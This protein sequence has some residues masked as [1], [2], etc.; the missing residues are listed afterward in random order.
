MPAVDWKGPL[1]RVPCSRHFK[2]AP[3][4]LPLEPGRQAS[5]QPLGRP[6]FHPSPVSGPSSHLDAVKTGLCSALSQLAH[7]SWTESA[8]MPTTGS[9]PPVPAFAR[10]ATTTRRRRNRPI[11]KG[12]GTGTAFPP[13]AKCE[14]LKNGPPENARSVEAGLTTLR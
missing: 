4:L 9:E 1:L 12:N 2:A 3:S 14:E 10:K 13:V 11:R 6:C 8:L 7:T 5:P